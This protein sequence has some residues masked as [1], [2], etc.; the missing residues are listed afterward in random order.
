V[1]W[2]EILEQLLAVERDDGN[3][4]EIR[5]MEVVVGGDV[6]LAQ[7]ERNVGGDAVERRASVLAEVAVGL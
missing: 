1:L 5:A 7:L 2:H 3:A 4:L 6:E